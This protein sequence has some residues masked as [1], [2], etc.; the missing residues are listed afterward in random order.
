MRQVPYEVYFHTD[1]RALIYDAHGFVLDA[2]T[3]I[4]P[5]LLPP[6]F[7]V[8]EYGSPYPP[9]LQRLVPGREHM[10]DDKLMPPVRVVDEGWM[11]LV[12]F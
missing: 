4:A 12:N 6:P 2:E 8:N 5:H 3:N 10:A 1:Y 9:A 7:L 11:V